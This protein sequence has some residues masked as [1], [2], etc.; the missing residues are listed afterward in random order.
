MR[1]PSKAVWLWARTR[2]GCKALTYG[3]AKVGEPTAGS[4]GLLRGIPRGRLMLSQAPK[5]PGDRGRVVPLLSWF[6]ST[7]PT[8]AAGALVWDERFRH[9]D[10]EVSG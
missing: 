3:K 10:S 5:V 8:G 4:V 7:T 2:Q 9:A 6:L 1:C